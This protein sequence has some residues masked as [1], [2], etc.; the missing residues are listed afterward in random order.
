M[1]KILRFFF[2]ALLGFI[3]TSVVFADDKTEAQGG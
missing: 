2:V 3:G 1:N